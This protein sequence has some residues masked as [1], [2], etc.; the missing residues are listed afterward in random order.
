MTE[1]G[2]RMWRNW[3]E[4]AEAVL[5][6]SQV[7]VYRMRATNPESWRQGEVNTGECQKDNVAR[8]VVK[9]GAPLSGMTRINAYPDTPKG[10]N[11]A[12]KKA[13]QLRDQFDGELQVNARRVYCQDLG[14][15]YWTV[16]AKEFDITRSGEPALAPRFK[17]EGEYNVQT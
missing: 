16:W 4:V 17:G 6:E 5:D 2:D 13:N 7:R 9:S 15:Y 10:K 11:A 8:S 1:V 3:L 14:D 12:H